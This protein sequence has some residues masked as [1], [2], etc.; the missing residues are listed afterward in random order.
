VLDNVPDNAPLA[1]YQAALARHWLII[2]L[3]T[4]NSLVNAQLSKMEA[5]IENIAT[6]VAVGNFAVNQLIKH[7]ATPTNI[8]KGTST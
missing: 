3:K 8:T 1:V 7:E 6:S 2:S 4:D 5:T